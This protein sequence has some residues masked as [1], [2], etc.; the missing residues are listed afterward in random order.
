MHG[1]QFGTV[2][3]E[4]EG[5]ETGLLMTFR[6]PQSGIAFSIPVTDEEARAWADKVLEDGGG[7]GELR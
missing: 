2:P 4:F 1:V 5:G 3:M 6:E 7:Q